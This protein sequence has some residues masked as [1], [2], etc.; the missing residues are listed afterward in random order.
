VVLVSVAAVS[1]QAHFCKPLAFPTCWLWF[2]NL[3]NTSSLPGWNILS[4]VA[5]TMPAALVSISL[6]LCDMGCV[7]LPLPVSSTRSASSIVLLLYGHCNN[8]L[9]LPLSVLPA[10][11]QAELVDRSS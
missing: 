11:S 4:M 7:A 5:V 3:T 2:L 8:R 6:S 9:C 1:E 10:M